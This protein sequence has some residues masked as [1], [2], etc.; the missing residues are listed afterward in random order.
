MTV[1]QPSAV[2]PAPTRLNNVWQLLQYAVT[3]S[4]PFPSGNSWPQA[5]SAEHSSVADNRKKS[6]FL[7]MIPPLKDLG[8]PSSGLGRGTIRHQIQ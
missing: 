7:D 5:G 8:V 6:D 2:Y 3:I 4:F 1:A